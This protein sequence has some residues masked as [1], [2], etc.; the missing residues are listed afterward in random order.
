MNKLISLD[1]KGNIVFLNYEHN[2]YFVSGTVNKEKLFYL[3]L[4][5]VTANKFS[6]DE[7]QTNNGYIIFT[8]AN[9]KYLATIS[10]EIPRFTKPVAAEALIK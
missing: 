7:I 8:A 5:A 10:I 6:V 4:G 2:K 3:T 9:N 1:L